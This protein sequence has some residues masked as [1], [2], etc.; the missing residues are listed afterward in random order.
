[1]AITVNVAGLA[2]IKIAA[3]GA[4]QDFGYTMDGARIT[5]EGF[6]VNVPGDE[7]GGDEGPPVEI[8]YLGEIVRV[9]LEMTKWDVSVGNVLS[10]RFKGGTAGVP[11]AAGSLVFS[12]GGYFRLVISAANAPWNFPCAT[13]IK[14][15]IEI[16]AGTKYSKLLVEF[17]CYKNPSAGNG[18]DAGVLYNTT[19]V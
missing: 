11:V 16:N 4:L 6:T 9:R 5:T 10:A 14:Q 13:L 15:P 17:E 8:Q 3:G 2:T 7:N 12:A 18:A 19:I 1:M